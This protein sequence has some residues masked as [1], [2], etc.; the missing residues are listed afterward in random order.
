MQTV[1]QITNSNNQYAGEIKHPTVKD[2]NLI[3]LQINKH[4]KVGDIILDCF[5]GSGTT[6]IACEQLNRR[7]IGIEINEKYYKLSKQRLSNIQTTLFI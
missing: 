6:A 2:I 5:L 3:K 7:W 4:S 1:Y